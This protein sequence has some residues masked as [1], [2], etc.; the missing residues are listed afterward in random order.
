MV[1]A[2]QTNANISE[3][4]SV[5]N[6][7]NIECSVQHGRLVRPASIRDGIFPGLTGLLTVG[8]T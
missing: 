6:T 1:V 8:R 3:K 2:L 4:N 5:M 7:W